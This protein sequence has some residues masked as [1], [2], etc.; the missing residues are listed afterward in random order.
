M[1]LQSTISYH[2]SS[3]SRLSNG[4]SKAIVGS[5]EGHV[6]FLHIFWF[7]LRHC[8]YRINQER[9]R[10]WFYLKIII[11]KKTRSFASCCTLAAHVVFIRLLRIKP[12]LLLSRGTVLY[13]TQYGCSH[14]L[15]PRP[16]N[17]FCSNSLHGTTKCDYQK[18][19]STSHVCSDRLYLLSEQ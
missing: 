7:A 4:S 16:P 14:R 17:L 5:R 13:C 19:N 3:I 9:T 8:C 1:R 2:Q 15:P 18:S 12:T 6:F 11:F 10:D